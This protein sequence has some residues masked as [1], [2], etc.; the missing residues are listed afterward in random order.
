MDY[1]LGLRT[2]KDQLPPHALDEFNVLEARLRENMRREE[3]YGSTE[4]RRSERA[5]VVDQLNRLAESTIGISFNELCEVA[6]TRNSQSTFP[7][8]RRQPNRVFRIG[9]R[10][11][12]EPPVGH[13]PGQSFFVVAA[14]GAVGLVL[15]VLGN[16]IAGWIQK[17][18][19]RNSFTPLGMI[20]IVALTI[21]G[22]VVGAWLQ[23]RTRSVTIGRGFYW[24]MTWFLVLLVLLAIA[25]GG[26]LVLIS[27]IQPQT[28]Y[29]VVDAG[30]KMKP[31]YDQVRD[32]AKI[33]T[34]SLPPNA[35]IG[36]RVYGGTVNENGG[37]LDTRQILPPNTYE[38][39]DVQFDAALSK[40]L[41]GGHGSMTAAILEALNADLAQEDR[42]V[43]MFIISSGLDSICD[44]ADGAALRVI[45]KFTKR[46]LQTLVISIGRINPE[47]SR[48]LDQVAAAF[49]GRHLHV[50][51]PEPLPFIVKTSSYYG[52]S[53]L[54][55]ILTP[56]PNK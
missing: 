13:V 1:E 16:L 32:Y 40:I 8:T 38:K 12:P 22:I 53:Y 17:D 14:T 4:T 48:V 52:Y 29:F 50:A 44:G 3:L 23:S 56:T 20:L 36:L 55:N 43:K 7:E 35:K 47:D 46:D 19:L 42:P 26:I 24:L 45:P 37:C 5:A 18:I 31:I 6:T 54:F 11:R 21:I 25:I 9:H 15:G 10:G 28:V 51:N 34:L 27:P 33:S 30:D 39:P 2:L 49:Q 41:P